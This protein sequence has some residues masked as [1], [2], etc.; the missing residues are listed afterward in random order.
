MSKRKVT[1]FTLTDAGFAALKVLEQKKKGASRKDVVSDALI[2]AAGDLAAQP[3]MS[4]RLLD[5]TATLLL[6][7]DIAA[8]TVLYGKL[9]E[10]LM[11]IRPGS[12]EA[13]IKVV[14][15][16]S[17]VDEQITRLQKVDSALSKQALVVRDLTPEEHRLGLRAIP[18]TKSRIQHYESAEGQK[19]KDAAHWL[20]IYKLVHKIL[21]VVIQEAHS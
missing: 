5:P 20:S 16:V 14:A 12:P 15:A 17:K 3:V 18:W 11:S 6:R 7:A 4:W 8:E 10:D 13:A 1:S 9:R 21:S 2:R 19:A